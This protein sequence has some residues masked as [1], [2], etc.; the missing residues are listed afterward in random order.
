MIEAQAANI[1]QYT[2]RPQDG[3][4]DSSVLFHPMRLAECELK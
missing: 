1:Y 4:N 2:Y 3:M